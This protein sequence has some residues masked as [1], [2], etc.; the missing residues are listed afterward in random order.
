MAVGHCQIELHYAHSCLSQKM[1]WGLS[2]WWGKAGT[3][4]PILEDEF[5]IKMDR[6]R[7]QMIPLEIS[8]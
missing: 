5:A 3:P 1:V 8:L 6:N 2:H 4:S 7:C